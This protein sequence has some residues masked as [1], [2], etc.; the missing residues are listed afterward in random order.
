MTGPSKLRAWLET[1][2]VR[3]SEFARTLKVSHVAVSD[4]LAGKATPEYP[5]AKKISKATGKRVRVTDWSPDYAS[6]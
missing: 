5:N 4:W 3:P 2:G 6:E 1:E